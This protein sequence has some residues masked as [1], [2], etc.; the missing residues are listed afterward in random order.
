MA[1]FRTE[2]EK[3]D[4]DELSATVSQSHSATLV[5]E[6]FAYLTRGTKVSGRLAF[7]GSAKIDSEVEGEIVAK[8]RVHIGINAIV[9]ARVKAAS[10]VVAGT[11]RG[12]ITASKKIEVRPS[13]NVVGN[14]SAPVLVIQEGVRIEGHCSTPV[15]GSEDP[16]SKVSPRRE[17]VAPMSRSRSEF[18]G[19]PPG[20]S[21]LSGS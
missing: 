17:R 4:K 15:A 7:G 8:D 1:L 16:K 2:P 6:G 9:T 11:V 21:R 20:S 12:D 13:A 5:V 18:T 10:V 19:L 3:I 14:L